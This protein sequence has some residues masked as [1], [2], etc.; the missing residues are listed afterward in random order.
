MIFYVVTLNDCPG[1]LSTHVLVVENPTNPCGA[2]MLGFI[3]PRLNFEHFVA[4]LDYLV[5]TYVRTL[6]V[7][8]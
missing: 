8:R 1:V 7:Y 5:G 4:V 6:L 3:D 2:Q